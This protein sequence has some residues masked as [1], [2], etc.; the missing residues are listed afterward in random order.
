MKQ[1]SE[2]FYQSISNARKGDIE[3]D[4]GRSRGIVSSGRPSYIDSLFLRAFICISL[5]QS[6]TYLLN[7]SIYPSIALVD[8]VLRDVNQFIGIIA[9]FILFLFGY[10]APRFIKFRIVIPIAIFVL[11]LC[12]VFGGAG[13]VL[14]DGLLLVAASAVKMVFNPW[15]AVMT[16]FLLI[17]LPKEKLPLCL[18]LG[19]LTSCLC[20]LLIQQIALESQTIIYFAINPVIIVLTSKDVGGLFEMTSMNPGAYHRA[21]AR[22]A[23]FIPLI[24]R[25]FLTIFF[26]QVAFGFSLHF[27]EERGFG[28]SSVSILIYSVIL[29]WVCV[30]RCMQGTDLF[31]RI[32]G[33]AIV[34]AMTLALLDNHLNSYI[35]STSSILVLSC[36]SMGF[37]FFF[38]DII[39]KVSARNPE[40][41]LCF[42]CLAT[43]VNAASSTLGAALGTGIGQ[44]QA[45]ESPYA[46][47]GLLLV[48][49]AF[50]AFLAIGLNGYSFKEVI[51]RVE[52]ESSQMADERIEASPL[53]SDGVNDVVNDERNSAI[54]I[55]EDHGDDRCENGAD[56]LSADPY[57]LRIEL[58]ALDYN[59]T[60]R[61]REVFDLLA[62]GRNG[63]YIEKKL[64]IS[65]NT[66][67]AHVKHIYQKLDIHSH[68]E[69]IS[70]V[71][72]SHP[73]P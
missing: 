55:E 59:L 49:I 17:K 3:I 40:N 25:F 7:N 56:D 11:C 24:S 67:K 6:G 15:V 66:V 35:Y 43:A 54:A 58:L 52:P 72:Q 46:A 23:S 30:D 70:I 64:C 32:L 4:A 31:V 45:S 8:P 44:M 13:V 14:G 10:F 62:H 22:P 69:L 38:W 9:G 34:G 37:K 27:G 16:F 50:V 36:A 20:S 65:R 21:P 5:S 71:R 2:G 41:A 39:A 19:M 47:I 61:E 12:A 48:I 73:M 63:A 42:I 1:A 51:D 53:P 18:A 26:F 29:I 33:V 68:Q 57:A 28:L 60:V